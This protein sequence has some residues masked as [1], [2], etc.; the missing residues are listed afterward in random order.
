MKFESISINHEDEGPAIETPSSAREEMIR[1]RKVQAV[2]S[3]PS[4]LTVG[5]LLPTGYPYIRSVLFLDLLASGKRQEKFK[6]I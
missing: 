3:I 1:I 5:T 2:S 4:F 6:C